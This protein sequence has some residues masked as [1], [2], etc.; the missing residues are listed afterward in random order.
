MIAPPLLNP[1]HLGGAL[2]TVVKLQLTLFMK[3]LMFAVLGLFLATTPAPAVPISE[4]EPNNSPATANLISAADVVQASIAAGDVDF[5]AITLTAGQAITADVDSGLDF[6]MEILG[7]DGT[8]QLAFSDDGDRP[9]NQFDPFLVFV[10]PAAGTYYIGVSAYSDFGFVGDHNQNGLYTLTLTQIALTETEPDNSPATAN[11]ISCGDEAKAS[12]AAGDVDFYAITLTAGQAITADLDS[13]GLDLIMEILGTDGTTQLA[14]ND[15]GLRPPNE[16]DPFLEF[17]APAAGTYYIG[18]SAF[19]DFG[20]IGAHSQNGLYALTIKCAAPPPPGCEV[21]KF[22]DANANGIND[23]G[24]AMNGWLVNIDG[25]NIVATPADVTLGPGAHVISEL[26]PNEA[27]WLPTTP[28]SVNI[29][30]DVG[31]EPTQI[32]FGNLCLGAGGGM[33]LGFWS[34]KNGLDLVAADDRALLASLCLRTANGSI[35]APA[36][37]SQLRSWL[38][39][40]NAVNMAY[41]LSAQ[42]AA[43]ELNVFNGKVS[44]NRL[45]YAPGCGNTGVGNNFITINDLMVAANVALCADGVT[46]DGDP[47][48]ANQECL[49]NA[50]NAANN[51]L[52]FVQLT[53]CPYTFA[54]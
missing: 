32:E 52:N 27:N 31:N 21:V 16:F 35:F 22:Y 49:K 46:P 48:R 6:I 23:D 9:P 18:V 40:A 24:I 54:H 2:R 3:L 28:T 33:G 14:F 8:T 53:P 36:N 43:M 17:V 47:N 38:L 37:N 29:I 15:D 5:Y 51:N 10:A 11:S 44:G 45:V 30:G 50:L 12:I 39:N 13:L 19:P 20:F 7:A 26:A 4:T 42:L 34:N 41:M 25:T 1:A